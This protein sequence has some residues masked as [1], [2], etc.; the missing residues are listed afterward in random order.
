[1]G[2]PRRGYMAGLGQAWLERPRPAMTAPCRQGRASLI[3]ICFQTYLNESYTGERSFFELSKNVEVDA[4]CHARAMTTNYTK[5]NV[6]ARLN[7]RARQMQNRVMSNRLCNTVPQNITGCSALVVFHANSGTMYI[8]SFTKRGR[9][10]EGQ[11]LLDFDLK[12][13]ILMF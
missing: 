4:K 6:T 12:C 7:C 13:G 3:S 1:M 11:A 8:R 2:L 10:L 9:N 5:M